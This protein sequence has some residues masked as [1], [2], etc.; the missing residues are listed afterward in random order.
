MN[1]VSLSFIEYR[2]SLILKKFTVTKQ[3]NASVSN[4]FCMQVVKSME[5]LSTFS[6]AKAGSWKH[7]L[8]KT[9]FQGSVFWAKMIIIH[10]CTY[11]GCLCFN[12]ARYSSGGNIHRGQVLSLLSR[13]WGHQLLNILNISPVLNSAWSLKKGS[14]AKFI[15]YLYMPL[16]QHMQFVHIKLQMFPC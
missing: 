3:L 5:T 8:F 6:P 12:Q 15:F 2:E 16:S 4:S 11:Q 1:D 10:G 9:S 7:F 13:P 14:K